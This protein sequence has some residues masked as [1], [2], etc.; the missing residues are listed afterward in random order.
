MARSSVGLLLEMESMLTV[1]GRWFVD[2]KKH[3]KSI[4]N[5]FALMGVISLW[6]QYNPKIS[7]NGNLISCCSM[8]CFSSVI[9]ESK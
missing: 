2:I 4:Q 6:L 1:L 3:S 5:Y 7:Q 9:K 8:C